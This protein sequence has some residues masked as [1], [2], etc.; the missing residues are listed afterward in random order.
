VSQR[1]CENENQPEKRESGRARNGGVSGGFRESPSKTA[2]GEPESKDGDEEKETE[3]KLQA[4][5]W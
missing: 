2:R 5:D 1:A 4:E 3:E